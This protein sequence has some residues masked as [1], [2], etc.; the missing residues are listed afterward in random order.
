[1]IPTQRPPS[2][3]TGTPLRSWSRITCRTVS[4][5]SATVTLTGSLPMMSRTVR[6]ICA[7][8]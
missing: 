8:A 3:T 6:A 4:T 5:E 7:A 2:L 1:M